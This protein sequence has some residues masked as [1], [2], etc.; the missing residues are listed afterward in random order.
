MAA[1]AAALVAG[2][3]MAAEG[4]DFAGT[5]EPLPSGGNGT[6]VTI[7]NTGTTTLK[8]ARI[9]VQG[10]ITGH[11]SHYGE[12]WQTGAPG[13]LSTGELGLAPG[14][15][16]A[17]NIQTEQPVNE[18][19]SVEVSVSSDCESDTT[20]VFAQAPPDNGAADLHVEVAR[21]DPAKTDIFSSAYG[22]NLGALFL[23]TV[24]ITNRGPDAALDVVLTITFAKFPRVR[25]EQDGEAV[26]WSG[27]R[28][29]ETQY[30][31]ENGNFVRATEG[32]EYIDVSLDAAGC[33]ESTGRSFIC[34]I[35]T[36]APGG[37]R[38]FL[39]P[40]FFVAAGQ[41]EL[42]AAGTTSTRD[43]GQFTNRGELAVELHTVPDSGAP[44]CGGG[45]QVRSSGSCNTRARKLPAGSAPTFRG[46]ARG[47]KAVDVAVLR[48]RRGAHVS[49][50]KYVCEWLKNRRAKFV[51]GHASKSRCLRPAAMLRAKGAD[52]WELELQRALPK[53][54]YLLFTRAVG[55]NGA[56]EVS[57][58]ATDGNRIE[59]I[60]G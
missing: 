12:T 35:G 60:V 45:R 22:G 56:Y 31:V 9:R 39:S 49:A 34:R 18:G 41:V 29:R 42:S 24:T 53:G 16:T 8:C 32:P 13:E 14:A 37:S 20:K 10:T 52:S 4:D 2:V 15:T 5:A 28:K 43:A 44:G 50:R 1:V 3:A 11:S 7:T 54:R 40:V 59:L 47:A 33:E 57:F 21:L 38:L 27:E 26:L 48:L 23:P 6:R 19:D 58:S 17:V 55:E 36:L 25:P 30:H 46:T 51:P